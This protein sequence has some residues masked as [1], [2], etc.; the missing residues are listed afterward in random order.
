MFFPN[1]FK[2]YLLFFYF[3][4]ILLAFPFAESNFG[5]Q[6]LTAPWLTHDI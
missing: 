2:M 4:T 3:S 6:N 1:K 5:K